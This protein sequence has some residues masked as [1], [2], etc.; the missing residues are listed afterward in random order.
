MN[1][2]ARR[3]GGR[4]ALVDVAVAVV[5]TLLIGWAIVDPPGPASP[6]PSWSAWLVGA[7]LSGP[8]VVRRRWP[9]PAL[10]AAGAVAVLATVLGAVAAGMIVLS[11]MPTVLVLYLVACTISPGRSAAALAGCAV[12][13]C[14]A[15]LFFYRDVL[16]TLPPA[17]A[18]SELPP[19]WPVEIG[20]ISVAM[21][22]AWAAGLLVRAR[23]VTSARLAREIAHAA[24][25]E[26]RL[27]ISRELHDVIGH[28]MSL[29]AVKA[30]VANH[31]ADAQPDEA[32]AALA[33]I[34]HTSRTTLAEIRRVL[35]GL[36]T[37]S[38]QHHPDLLP[39][40]LADLRELADR[41]GSAGVEVD[42]ALVGD[43]PLP[44]VL[45][46]TVYRIVQEGLTNVL[47][48]TTATRCRVAVEVHH[49]EVT[50]E[51]TNPGPLRRSRVP[52]GGGYGLIG[53]RERVM[54]Y[55][56]SFHAGPIPDDGFRV[57]A[58]LPFEPS[59]LPQ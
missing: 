52:A 44:A 12:A 11:F 37:D 32:R 16:P 57:A 33:A 29:I 8:V 49:Q 38:D 47:A 59:G 46:P 58:R 43:A 45:G 10:A 53:M 54:L 48:H 36:R 56:G 19:Y 34:E 20:T 25:V 13:A 41:I 18:V 23:R 21:V 22:I 28:S 51:I 1:S 24:V 26:E 27:R 39:T 31:V 2:A 15:I 50:I 9:L 3:L 17:P 14:A 42:L 4:R 6:W 30:T 55:G 35:G 5:F 7:A 40:G